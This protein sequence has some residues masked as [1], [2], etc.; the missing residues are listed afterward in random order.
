MLCE[1]SILGPLGYEPNTLPLRHK[2][3]DICEVQNKFILYCIGPA[4]DIVGSYVPRE[5]HS[6]FLIETLGLT[7]S[8]VLQ[9]FPR[10]NSSF[11]GKSG[12]S[13]VEVS[14]NKGKNL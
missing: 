8:R 5:L 6:F 12:G 4:R 10:R 9:D 7:T 14:L 2:A 3:L 11:R 13:P 1:V